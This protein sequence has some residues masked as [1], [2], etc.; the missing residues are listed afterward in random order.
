M[1]AED[2]DKIVTGDKG[3]GNCLCGKGVQ[4]RGG[5]SEGEG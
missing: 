5:G 4:Q 2:R 3:E 1:M